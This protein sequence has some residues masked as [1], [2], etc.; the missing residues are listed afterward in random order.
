MKHYT[1]WQRFLFY[2]VVV[3]SAWT[4]YDIIYT[5]LSPRAIA[6]SIGLFFCFIVLELLSELKKPN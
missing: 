6:S 5:R 4:L 3:L 2:G 1:P